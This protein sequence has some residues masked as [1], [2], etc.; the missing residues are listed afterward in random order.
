MTANTSPTASSRPGAI[1]LTITGPYILEAMHEG[2]AP[3]AVRVLISP[4]S[5]KRRPT[6]RK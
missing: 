1:A 6:I 4:T 5:L 3:E 2:N